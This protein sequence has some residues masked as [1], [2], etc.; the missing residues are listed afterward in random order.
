M[1]KKVS[2]L[3]A[4]ESGIG[5]ALLAQQQGYEVW[6]SDFGSIPAHYKNTLKEHQIPFEEGQ[7]DEEKILQSDWVIKSPGIPQKA[8]IIKKIK[9][10][11]ILISSEIELASR[12]AKAPII[13]IT[14]SNGKTTTTSL[15]YHILKKANLQSSL[16]GNIG[17][18]F[19][20]SV[21]ENPKPDY[22]V[23]E[24]S[25]FQLDDI[26]EFKP[27]VAL[28]LNITPDHLDEYEN[29][30]EKYAQAKWKITLNQDENDF[31]ILNKEDTI[32]QELRNKKPTQAQIAEFSLIQQVER[33]ADIE[34]EE[35]VIKNLNNTFRMKIKELALTGKHNVANSM[36]VA[37]TA[38]IVN[39]KNETIKMGLTDFDTVPHRLEPVLKIHG[40]NFINDSKATNVNSVYYALE[41]MDAPVV[42]IAGGKDKGNDY[43]ELKPLVKNKVK[44]LICLGVDNTALL[45]NFEDIV[46]QIIETQDMG[47]A[48]RA[49]YM[50]AKK[51]ET[52]LLSPA[53]ASFDLFDNYEDRGEQFKKEVRKL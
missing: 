40:I 21:Y 32:I 49:A 11:G 36:A 48:V 26:Q 51:G 24:V 34:N 1:K 15:I 5:A 27:Y 22:F 46:P 44:A 53:C 33:G 41:C 35:I 52:V 43:S 25:S 3:G 2:I 7:H 19:A 13:A 14:G 16:V 23:L 39:I 18:S 50:M 9:A 38:K 10:K 8:S 37:T 12:F 29:S 17:N 45:E 47:E 31:L 30:I 6:V 4:K 28:L 20:L 42:W